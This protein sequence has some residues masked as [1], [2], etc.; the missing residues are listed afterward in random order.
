MLIEIITK[1][2]TLPIIIE[3][4]VESKENGPN[5]DQT[6]IYFDWA[7]KQYEDRSKYFTPIYIYLYPEYKSQM[8][9]TKEYIRMTYQELVDFI[10]DPSL[11]NCG[12][13]ISKNNFKMYL[14]CLSFQSDNEKGEN[15]MA[16]STEERE[17]FKSFILE[18]KDLLC[19]VLERLKELEDID[20]DVDSLDA[21]TDS[22]RDNTKYEFNGQ[23]Y[24]KGR[25]VLAVVQHY[26]ND[27]KPTDFKAL[28]DAFP[29][30]LRGG[31]GVVQVV[32]AIP[33]K[34]KGIGG[35]K[36]YY[37]ETNEIIHLISGEDVLVS[38]QWGGAEKM[39]KFIE[40]VTTK[41]K[42]DIKKI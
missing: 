3:N 41:L 11:A 29:S 13:E 30:K 9:K 15:T 8:Q 31:S 40:H 32:D 38:D 16:I 5:Q 6:K 33:D 20:I 14:Q 19:A 10:L 2:K 39:D 25:L 18:N 1:E 23:K 12:D 22:I 24:G 21:V 17:I 36:R 26:V 42:Y 37:I 27:K 28:E 34:D 4:K 35:T 7:E